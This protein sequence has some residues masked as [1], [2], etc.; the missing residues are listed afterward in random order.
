MNAKR[1]TPQA[2]TT[3]APILV[4]PDAIAVG[5]IAG[6]CTL[7]CVKA[8][9]RDPTEE[10]EFNKLSSELLLLLLLLLPPLPVDALPN[11]LANTSDVDDDET[12]LDDVDG[13]IMV[14]TPAVFMGG[15]LP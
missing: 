5:L 9:S 13:V 7:F 2:I 4:D 10:D 8:A 11:T 14:L 15:V 6:I 1:A 3:E 12:V